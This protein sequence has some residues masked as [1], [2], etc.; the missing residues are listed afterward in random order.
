MSLL[1]SRMADVMP[2]IQSYVHVHQVAACQVR[3][4]V[5]RF[6]RGGNVC[7]QQSGMMGVAK[8]CIHN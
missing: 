7:G 4:Y 8:A 6:M 2:E 1:F 3:A 5:N